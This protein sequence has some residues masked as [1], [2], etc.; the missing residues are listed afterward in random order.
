MK[1]I[2]IMILLGALSLNLGCG[3]GDGGEPDPVCTPG[4]VRCEGDAVEQCLWSATGWS[5]VEDCSDGCDKGACV[6]VCEPL[7]AGAECGGDGCGGTCGDCDDGVACVDG[8]CCK[9]KCG[10]KDC[11]D[12][13]CG[14]D[15]G[16]CADL[17]GCLEGKCTDSGGCTGCAPWQICEWGGC[18]N[19]DSLGECPLGGDALVEDCSGHDEV[20]C[21]GGDDLYYCGYGGDECPDEMETCL[22]FLPCG[23]GGSTCGWGGDFFLCVDP[24]AAAA[25][26]GTLVCEWF[27]CEATCDGKSCGGDGCGGDCGECSDGEICEDGTCV[28]GCAD[29]C[30]GITF[31]GCCD[32]ALSVYCEEGELVIG[33]C[34]EEGC[35]WLADDGWYDCGGVG[36]DPDGGL[37]MDCSAGYDYPIGCDGKECGDD[38]CGGSCGE[39]ADGCTCTQGLCTDCS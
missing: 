19:P 32:G 14:G 37:P 22:C 17:Q 23:M 31:D 34:G 12:D 4:E 15:C 38:G 28:A 27:P 30:G 18:R 24:P 26:D 36:E 25:P 33:D 5:Q 2:P 29:P 3:S 6:D 7:C 39:C 21:C 13:G 1:H 10:G 11:G 8:T 16:Q 9:P 20:G 35:G